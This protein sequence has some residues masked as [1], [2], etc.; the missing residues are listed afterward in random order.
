M[1]KRARNDNTQDKSRG[2]TDRSFLFLAH[3][4]QCVN[5]PFMW[6]RSLN[7]RAVVS[8]WW[9]WLLWPVWFAVSI[10]YLI[11]P[12]GFNRT[13]TYRFGQGM[14]GR[15][16]LVRN[17]AWHYF[18]PALKPLVR[19]RVAEAV[20]AAQDA[21]VQVV[22]L[23]A[24]N[25]AEWLNGGGED[26]VRDLGDRLKV[27]VVHGD[28]MTAAVVYQR[29]LQAMAARGLQR[30]RVF[31]TGGTS[32]TGRAIALALARDGVRVRLLTASDERFEQIRKAAGTAGRLLSRARSLDDGADCRLWITG[33]SAPANRELAEAIPLGAVVVNFSVP[34]PLRP[35]DLR[36]RSDLLHLD[37]GLVAYNPEET[38]MWF[39][40]GLRKGL[41]YACH[42][43]TIVHAHLGWRH[44]EV[45]E[46]KVE[47]ME[48][49]W[50]AAREI[51]LRLP[52]PT[53][54]HRPVALEPTPSRM[55]RAA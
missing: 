42:A 50:R 7:Q 2:A 44:H 55:R 52:E 39:T 34:D 22:G 31:V 38:D 13:D 48:E 9:L 8:W 25:K 37:A 20:L 46:V 45:G 19:G 33:K 16:W 53:S 10:W 32:K 28:T 29:V 6:L 3:P 43:G 24:L 36:S 12:A 18:V 17:F 47:Q 23:G 40:L 1:A 30:T 27:P 15:S 54:H 5:A 41:L 51:G 4:V 21:G 26:L 11:N 35:E 49:V 14:T